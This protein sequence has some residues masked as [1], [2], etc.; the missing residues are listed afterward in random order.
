MG[1]NTKLVVIVFITA[2]LLWIAF[3]LIQVIKM[4]QAGEVKIYDPNYN[5]EYI[6]KDGK[7]YD[8]NYNLKFRIFDGKIYDQNWNKKG[9]IEKKGFYHNKPFKYKYMPQR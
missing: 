5:L 6:I 8:S 1:K 9:I 7:V 3:I 4:A 2:L